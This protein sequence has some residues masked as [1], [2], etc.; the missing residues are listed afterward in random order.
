MRRKD[1]KRSVESHTEDPLKQGRIFTLTSA[2]LVQLCV[3][4]IYIWSIFRVPVMDY[5]G[6]NNMQASLIFSIMIPMNM[7]GVLVGGILCDRIGIRIVVFSGG[8]L[9]VSGLL[10]TSFVTAANGT[11]LYVFY[12]GMCGFGGGLAYASAVASVNQWWAQ[13]KGLVVG[14]TIGAYG[15]S[16]VVFG[17]W[18]NYMLHSSL[19]VLG[20]F[21]TLA[22]AFL[23]VFGIAGWMVRNAPE[24]PTSKSGEMPDQAVNKQKQYTPR[25]VLSTP[26]YYLLVMSMVCVT[27]PYLMLNTTIKSF[28]MVRGLTADMAVVT[29]MI[30]GIASALGR[31]VS[32]WMTDKTSVKTVLTALFCLTL[33]AMGALAFVGGVWFIVAIAL[34]T[35]AY[36]GCAAISPILAISFFGTKYMSSNMGL[37]LV[38]AIIAGTVFPSIA[39]RIG[40]DGLPSN[41]TFIVAVSIV[42]TG[43][44]VFRVLIRAREK[45]IK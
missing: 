33:V 2:I 11:L 36:G 13:H 12:S 22:I 35:F 31:I 16:T 44:V 19:G 43:L 18:V 41:T 4:I 1:W 17:A 42:L 30:T 26:D 24:N 5:L 34:V 27:A 20:T 23:F 39:A 40:V 9:A 3:G 6:W 15:C 25:E 37:L 38:S 8:I 10:L 32:A 21:R 14:L 28:G 7:I 29:V 45:K